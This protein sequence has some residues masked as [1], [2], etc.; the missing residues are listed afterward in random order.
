LG[1]QL[2]SAQSPKPF[3]AVDR[4]RGLR[5]SLRFEKRWMRSTIRA[6]RTR[7]CWRTRFGSWLRR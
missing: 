4:Y 6:I 7:T 2:R 1:S 3:I 5:A